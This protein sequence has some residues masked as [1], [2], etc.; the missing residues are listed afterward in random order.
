MIDPLARSVRVF[1]C[2]DEVTSDGLGISAGWLTQQFD[3]SESLT[4]GNGRPEAAVKGVCSFL[5]SW[6]SGDG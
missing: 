2:L 1:R 4:R 3:R 5:F 6:T